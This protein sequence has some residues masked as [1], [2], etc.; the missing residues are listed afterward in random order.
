MSSFD[1]LDFLMTHFSRQILMLFA[2]QKP[3]GIHGLAQPARVALGK[4]TRRALN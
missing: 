2:E 3:I 1:P 4:N